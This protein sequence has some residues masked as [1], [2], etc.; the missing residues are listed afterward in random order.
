MKA[1][2]AKSPDMPAL[3]RALD[4]ESYEWMSANVPD[5]LRALE[6]EIANGHTPYEA[7]ML[8]VQHSGREEL[9]ARVE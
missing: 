6:T 9:A 2:Q 4:Q 5:I 1:P 7:R 3:Q 8:V